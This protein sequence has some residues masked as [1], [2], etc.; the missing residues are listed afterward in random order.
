MSKC[1]SD[2]C[3]KEALPKIFYCDTCVTIHPV[4]PPVYPGLP[5][6]QCT[7][8]PIPHTDTTN[9]ITS[10]TSFTGSLIGE[11]RSTVR[12]TLSQKYPKYYKPVGSL[13]EID[14]YNVHHL[15]DIQDPAGCIQHASKKLLLSG[16]RTG[17][18]SKRQDIQ[19]AVDTLNRW[20][21]L[22]PET[23]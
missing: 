22:N 14:V 9:S 21:A 18:K 5:H 7:A 15:F 19:E 17:G 23:K 11:V 6:K 20:L 1:L 3:N 10:A 8:V 13:T 12:Q 16:V 4:R 2:F